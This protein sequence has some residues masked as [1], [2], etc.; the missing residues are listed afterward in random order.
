MA[1]QASAETP[2]GEK[3]KIKDRAAYVNWG[4]WFAACLYTIGFV[5]LNFWQGV[6]ALVMWPYYLDMHFAR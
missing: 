4:L 2:R 5:H 3:I 6:I 1:S